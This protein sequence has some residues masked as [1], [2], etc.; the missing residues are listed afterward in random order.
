VIGPRDACWAFISGTIESKRRPCVVLQIECSTDKPW[1][2]VIFGQEKPG[3][4]ER[5]AVQQSS[6]DGLT[7]RLTKDTFFRSDGV[8]W[9]LAEKL[10]P[11]RG[12]VS[13]ALYYEL[14]VLFEAAHAAHRIVP[15]PKSATTTRSV[16]NDTIKTEVGEP[17]H[18][19]RES[20]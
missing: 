8:R 1:A 4:V 18:S 3:L 11:S 9:I 15:I 12:K 20:E 7:L 6:P 14:D 17:D 19:K 2:L 5:Y 10:D 13:P 16:S